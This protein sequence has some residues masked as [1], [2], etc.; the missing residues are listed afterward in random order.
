MDKNA[1]IFIAGHRGMVGSAIVRRLQSGGYTNLLT[2][3][4]QQ[5]DLLDQQSVRDFLKVEKPDYIFLAAAKVGGIHA[6][7]TYRTDFI[8]QNLQ[9]Q[10]NIIYGALE[11]GIKDLCFLGSSCIYPSNCPQPIKE[12]YLLT[13]PLEPT[14]EPY[15]IAKIAGIKLCES[16]NRQHGT[17]Y[18]SVMPTNLYGPN[19]NYD[20]A[21]SHVL[22]ATIRKAHEAK[23]LEESECI[24]WGTGNPRREFLYV[25]DMAD[26]CVFLMEH[27]I[28]S[29]LYNVGTG[30]DVTIRELAEI[31]MKV[32]GFQGKMTFDTT[33]PDGPLRK[34]LDVSRM[35][36]LGWTHKVDL[37]AGV[38]LTYEAFRSLSLQ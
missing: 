34:L 21:N 26:A 23:L 15:A 31:V 4:R 3:T 32:V 19:D 24:V 28:H 36:T 1:K 14:N 18:V 16:C 5:L 13:G 20:L 25:D 27:G 37:K 10:N 35:E 12:D 2:R 30:T 29:G 38:Q 8:Y 17:R 6:N 9:I 22:P 11:S 33:K 7:N